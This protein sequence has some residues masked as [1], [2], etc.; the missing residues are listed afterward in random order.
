[1]NIVELCQ[2]VLDN[3]TAVQFRTLNGTIES[4]DAFSKNKKT[5]TFLDTWTASTVTKVYN[6]LSDS[7]KQKM[8][9]LDPLKAIAICYKLTS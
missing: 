5:W 2:S 4:R 3:R 9:A 7:S 8:L 6:A 1:M